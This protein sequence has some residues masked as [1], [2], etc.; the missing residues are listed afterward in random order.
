ILRG[1]EEYPLLTPSGYYPPLVPGVTALL[2]RLAG[3]SYATAL[4][5]N[6]LFLALLLAG[7]WRLGDRMLG[8]P[9]GVLAALLLLAAPGIRLNAGEYM[10]DL[11]LTAMVVLSVLALL[12]TE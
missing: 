4:A 10:L 1:S 5:T 9:M 8:K 12:C 6:L 7:T 3:R 2:Y 11:P